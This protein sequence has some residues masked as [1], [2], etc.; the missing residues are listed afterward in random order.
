MIFGMVPLLA[1]LASVFVLSLVIALVGLLVVYF[2]KT[3][4]KSLVPT[5]FIACYTFYFCLPVAY[6]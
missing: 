5:P 4:Y 2:I 1:E 6:E 3:P